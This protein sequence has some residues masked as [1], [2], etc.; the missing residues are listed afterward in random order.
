MWETIKTWATTQGLSL[1][2][3]ALKVVVIAVIGILVLRLVNQLQ[4]KILEKSKMVRAAHGRIL[5]LA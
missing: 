1:A 5:T 4:P 2:T 3:V